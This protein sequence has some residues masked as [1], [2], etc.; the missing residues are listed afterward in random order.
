MG[1]FGFG[2]LLPC[3]SQGR[4]NHFAPGQAAA[5]HHFSGRAD[6]SQGK[7]TPL[8]FAKGPR[9]LQSGLVAKS[10]S[11]ANLKTAEAALQKAFEVV[12]EQP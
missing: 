7:V 3:C 6:K 5:D 1:I 4:D 10:Q 8:L 9:S 11:S 2:P 12:A